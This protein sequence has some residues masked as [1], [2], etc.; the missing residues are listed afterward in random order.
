MAGGADPVKIEAEHLGFEVTVYPHN[1]S[2]RALVTDPVSGQPI[3]LMI[4][5][6]DDA[7][8]LAD[9]LRIAANIARRQANPHHDCPKEPWAEHCTGNVSRETL[10]DPKG[11]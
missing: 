6:P 9:E 5:P 2:V 4:L 3:N 10:R 1:G 8:A 7:Q 11:H